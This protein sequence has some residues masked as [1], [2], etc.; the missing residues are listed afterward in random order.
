MFS[1]YHEK[2]SMPPYL[3]L[4]A[5]VHRI[6]DLI[7]AGEY[8][9]FTSTFTTNEID[10]IADQ[11]KR[12]KMWRLIDDYGITVL[13]TSPKVERLAVMYIQ[14]G[15]VTS[16]WTTDASHIAITA[17]YGL[18]FI[19]SLNFTHIVRAW[20]V[21]RVRRMNLREGV[22]PIKEIHAI[23]LKLQDETASMTEAERIEFI[24]NKGRDALAR[25]GLSSRIS[26]LSANAQGHQILEELNNS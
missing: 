8:E 7:K 20:T 9:P 22:S 24:N 25:N 19:V 14:E 5:E 23:R 17:V 16:S 21:E 10:G 26:N 1:F 15:A 11:E 3:E 2:R 13:D 18:D 6:F 12:A 4:K